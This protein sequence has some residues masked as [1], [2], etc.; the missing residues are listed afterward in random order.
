MGKKKPPGL[1]KAGE[2]GGGAP[3]SDALTALAS[4][5]G[6]AAGSLTKAFTGLAGV[7][8]P[9]VAAFSPAIVDQLNLAFKTLT[10]TVGMA[11]G[12][13]LSIMADVVQ[14]VAASL[15]PVMRDL[16]P[17]FA[18]LAKTIADAIT[19]VLRLLGPLLQ[20]LVPAIKFMAEVFG[21]VLQ[22]LVRYL[23]L[24]IGALSKFVGSGDLLNRMI[25]S[26]SEK[27]AP[28]AAPAAAAGG[29][30]SVDQIAKDVASAAFAAQGRGAERGTNDFLGEIIGQLRT[31]RD[32]NRGLGKMITD[33]LAD[34]WRSAWAE[35]EKHL[36]DPTRL[37]VGGWRQQTWNPFDRRFWIND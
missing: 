12:P 27:P 20:S 24:A 26:L 34:W 3:K 35:I 1:G 11:F 8:T 18:D 29:I 7:M 36:P 23:I 14:E 19:P 21:R 30:R 15:A 5:L 4:S 25:T 37:G 22:E 6:D 10:A 9:F 33:S 32:D 28:A 16:A 2:Q 31:L 17:V 13:A